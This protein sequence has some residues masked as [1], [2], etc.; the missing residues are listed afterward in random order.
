MLYSPVRFHC[1]KFVIMKKILRQA[2]KQYRN[3]PYLSKNDVEN[4]IFDK[5]FKS[6]PIVS[7]AMF[8]E[9]ETYVDNLKR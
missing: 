1:R 8:A 5:V 9:I 2:K 6:F 4:A 7:A 3:N